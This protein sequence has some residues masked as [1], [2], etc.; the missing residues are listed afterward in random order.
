MSIGPV[1]SSRMWETMTPEQTRAIVYVQRRYQHKLAARNPDLVNPTINVR[2]RYLADQAQELARLGPVSHGEGAS[3][4]AIGRILELAQVLKPTHYC[5]THSQSAPRALLTDLQTEAEDA[6]IPLPSVR[7]RKQFRVPTEYYQGRYVNDVSNAADFFACYPRLGEPGEGSDWALSHLLM[8]V[9]AR[10]DHNE[11]GESAIDMFLRRDGGLDVGH[12]PNHF[13][14]FANYYF[15]HP[16]LRAAMVHQLTMTSSFLYQPRLSLIAVPKKILKNPKTRFGYHASPFGKKCDC[17]EEE[18]AV[19]EGMQAG[20]THEKG[21]YRLFP[22]VMDKDHRVQTF[23]EDLS[24]TQP[25]PKGIETRESI[26]AATRFFRRLEAMDGTYGIQKIKK[27]FA[28]MPID[29]IRNSDAWIAAFQ[30]VIQSKLASLPPETAEPLHKALEPHQALLQK[31]VTRSFDT[32]WFNRARQP[33]PRSY[34]GHAAGV[35]LAA[36]CAAFIVFMLLRFRY[37]M[38]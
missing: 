23:H 4:V 17:N 2:K 13:N 11:Q 8:S 6:L 30:D 38:L 1:S 35:A 7:S 31:Q 10:L 25:L 16:T 14:A 32:P 26:L 15:T 18:I 21:Q 37:K 34:V 3:K 12:T 5:F 9:D 24:A 33:Q 20:T 27:L 19:L 22:Y 28:E 29:V 36:V